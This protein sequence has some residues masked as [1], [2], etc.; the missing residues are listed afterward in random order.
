MT[1]QLKRIMKG[2]RNNRSSLPETFLRKGALKI[3]C[4]FTRE[5]PY[6][7]VISIKLLCNFIEITL[8]HGCSPINLMHIYKKSFPKKTT[9]GLLLK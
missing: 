5:L 3:Y 2:F 7:S 4:K 6:R 8:R 9:G 1:L